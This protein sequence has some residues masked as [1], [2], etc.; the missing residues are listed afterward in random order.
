LFLFISS[1]NSTKCA[2]FAKCHLSSKVCKID[3]VILVWYFIL[4]SYGTILSSLEC[5]RWIFLTWFLRFLRFF[6]S[7]Q[8]LPVDSQANHILSNTGAIR[9]IECIDFGNIFSDKY[10][11]IN[12]P[13]RECHISMIFFSHRYW[14]YF[15]N[16]IF[17]AG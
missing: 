8:K 12:I 2:W 15:S 3:Q 10:F 1:N 9:W 17:Q 14:K 5:Q 4:C 13:P 11:A 16:H 7:N 6:G